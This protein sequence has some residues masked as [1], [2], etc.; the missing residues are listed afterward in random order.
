MTEDVDRPDKYGVLGRFFRNPLMWCGFAVA[1]F[2]QG[3]NGLH[4]YYPDVPLVP[5]EIATWPLF[6]EAPWNQM[7]WIVMRVWPVAVGMTYLLSSEVSFSLWFFYWFIKAQLVF[8]YYFGF[9]PNSLPE[10][11]ESGGKIFVVFQEAGAYVA[12][13]A[14]TLWMGR[15]HLKHVARRACMPRSNNPASKEEKSEAL[16]YPVAFWGFVLSFAFL[17]AWGICAGLSIGLALLLWTSYLIIAIVM[18]RVVVGGGLLFVHHAHMP[19]GVVSQLVGSGPG[20]LLS[21]AQG[22][23]PAAIIETSFI[24]DYRGSLMPSFIQSFKLAHDRGINARALFW[25]L[26]AVIVI[27]LLVSMQMI[28]RLGY[29]HGGLQLG[30]WLHEWGP[31]MAGRSAHGLSQGVSH[32]SW[33]N[34]LWIGVGAAIT[35][36]LILARSRFAWFPLHPIG[37]LMC[38]TYPMN[39][40]WLSIFI[41]WLAKVLITR[42][43]GFDNYRKMTPA[44]LGLALGDIAMMLLWLVIDGWQGRTAHQLMPG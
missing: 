15:E 24:Q 39:T 28:V 36:S 6:T 25:L 9:P 18:S 11:A 19:L 16:S 30:R 41:G 43:G 42:F 13:V 37:F 3:L 12:Y 1:V 34:S 23:V 5:L 32:V 35:G 4:L 21:P 22:V 38:Q 7:G 44:F 10:A 29:E 31:Q 17:V 14:I 8:A 33:T 27:S 26:V 20:T 40:L 2:I